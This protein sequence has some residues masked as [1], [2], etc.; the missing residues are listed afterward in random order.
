MRVLCAGDLHLGRRSSKI[1][2]HLDGPG[3]SCSA[4]W[5]AIVKIAIAEQ[6]D[7][8]A[9]SGD[10]V[11]RDNRYFEAYGPLERGLHSLSEAGIE[12]FAVAGNHDFDVLPRL[13]DTLASDRFHLLGK[14][15]RWERVTLHRDGRPALHVDGWSFPREF[16]VD[17]PLDDYAFSQDGVPILGMLHADLDQPQS[18]YGP[19]A[20]ADL[21]RRPVALWLLGHV[22]GP[23]LLGDR[24]GP[25]VLYPGSPQAMD[26]GETG[27]HGVWIADIG[28]D[29]SGMPR[30]A[31]TSSV[32]Y[33]PVVL[34]LTGVEATDTLEQRLVTRVRNAL[35]ELVTRTDVGRLECLCCRVSLTGRT[36]L[37]RQLGAVARNAV[38][39]LTPSISGVTA[40]VEKILFETR[41]ALD[42][43]V[44]AARPDPPGEVAR[45]IRSLEAE[46]R[47]SEYR[48]L[49]S[50]TVDR[51]REIHSAKPF[52]DIASDSEPDGALAHRYVLAEAWSLL[53][54]LVAQKE[55][56]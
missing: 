5:E 3:Y 56:A 28:P 19:V 18:R 41:P 42:L 36:S 26:P 15:G 54:A 34:D 50:A 52:A 37:H 53:D 11:D 22:H 31:P 16:V 33:L 48:Q 32:C 30:L 46:E 38:E 14:S 9:L 51:L 17:N 7:L 49:V 27:V 21:Q 13:D 4:A 40:V 23:A 2:A 12:I 44:L 20:L 55:E 1:P 29:G 10:L 24:A 39:D 43:T 45:L 8:V 35:T 47:P 25:L 6:V